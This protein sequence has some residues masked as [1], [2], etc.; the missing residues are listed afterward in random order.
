MECFMSLF[1]CLP[2]SYQS[3][4]FLT[5][6][7]V[8]L[9]LSVFVSRGEVVQASGEYGRFAVSQPVRFCQVKG[10]ASAA[11]SSAGSSALVIELWPLPWSFADNVVPLCGPQQ[12]SKT[13][14]LNGDF[15]SQGGKV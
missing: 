9:F 7:G 11:P 3:A 14:C 4:Q 10:V 13:A 2:V 1:S 12:W 5:K 8:E 6:W 15:L